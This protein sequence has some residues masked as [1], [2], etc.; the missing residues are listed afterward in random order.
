MTHQ[1]SVFEFLAF[2]NRT[3]MSISVVIESLTNKSLSFKI[4]SYHNR[5]QEFYNSYLLQH[6]IDMM[7]RNLMN[8]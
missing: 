4:G 2:S 7:L 3:I 6:L 5:T 1:T 8:E